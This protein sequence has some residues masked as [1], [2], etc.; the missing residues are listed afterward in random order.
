MAD[1][2]QLR[3]DP[4]E[5]IQT[6]LP[7]YINGTLRQEESDVVETHLAICAECRTELELERKLARS[8]ASL[9]LDVE[10]G[11]AAMAQRLAE[12]ETS[13]GASRRLSL[14]ARK[15]PI[16]WAIAGPLAAAASVALAFTFVPA[17]EP[18]GETYRALG[19]PAADSEGNAVVLFKP[20]TTTQQVQVILSANHARIVDGP[21]PAG[22][23][24]LRIDPHKRDTA[25]R[26]LRSA[27]QIVLAEPI[28]PEG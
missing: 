10:H 18:A 11:W 25:L 19:T 23:L 12:S 28:G 16:G 7:W 15:V 5:E 17:P 22:A 1:I 27:S 6:L 2:F 21:N 9:P 24:V 20:E 26:E 13:P 8:V 4:H 14:F 3:G